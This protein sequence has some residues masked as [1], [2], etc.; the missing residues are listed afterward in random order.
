MG[1]TFVKILAIASLVTVSAC[2]TTQPAPKPAAS[3]P[4]NADGT[5]PW[6]DLPAPESAFV[7]TAPPP[8]KIPPGAK[9][10]SAAQLEASMKA[11][12]EQQKPGTDVPTVSAK[13]GLYGYVEVFNR[14]KR[15]CI[16]RGAVPTTL[17]SAHKT[18][19]VNY[20]EA[21]GDQTRTRAVMRPGDGALLRLDWTIPFCGD[22]LADQTIVME[23]P[24]RG[25]ELLAHVAKPEQPG[26]G[27]SELHPES[28]TYLTSGVFEEGELREQHPLDSP[29][30]PVRVTAEGSATARPGSR[31]RYVIA[32]AN[33][34][35]AE[36]PLTPCPG[37]SEERA[38][39]ARGAVVASPPVVLRFLNCRTVRSI[40][41]MGALRFEMFAFV[42]RDIASGTQMIITWTFWARWLDRS[43]ADLVARLAVSIV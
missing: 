2:A 19:P 8:R 37:Y 14:S 24:N 22:A 31:V 6:I 1:R 9:P 38:F 42:P 33:P 28:K 41:S 7:E 27:T 43:A 23:L 13:Y 40:P 32:L 17:T 36:I 5:I 3:L 4:L 18:V 25:G 34:T 20:A 35:A 16:L 30:N 29:Y 11:W 10:C 26:C 15:A 12:I 39:D 21:T